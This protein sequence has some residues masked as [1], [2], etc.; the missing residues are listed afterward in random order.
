MSTIPRP[1]RILGL[2]LLVCRSAFAETFDDSIANLAGN[3]A[4]GISKS[5]SKKVSVVDFTDLQ[6]HANELGRFV[7]EELSVALVNAGKGF[8]VMDRANLN[9]LLDEHKLTAQGLVNPENAKKLG[10][11][12]GVDAI[13]IGNVTAFETSVTITAKVI[14]TETTEVIAAAKVSAPKSSEINQLIARSEAMAKSGGQASPDDTNGQAEE[15]DFKAPSSVCTF[16]NI[17]V[18]L[19]SFRASGESGP[20]ALLKIQNRSGTNSVRIGLNHTT[21]G[22]PEVALSDDIG[23]DMALPYNGFRGITLPNH[24]YAPAQNAFQS[25]QMLAAKNE[26]LLFQDIGVLPE[27]GPSQSAMV[28]FKF[29]RPDRGVGDVFRLQAEIV[30]VEVVKGRRVNV[31]LN[32]VALIGIRPK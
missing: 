7:A 4:A 12:S 17:A 16:T 32:N 10:Q 28:E 15:K 1:L 29:G 30:A 19:V 26:S 22:M 13:V 27:I 9:R 11:F 3:V 5:S 14:S 24:V 23:N 20:V 2:I 6:G 31:T 21:S 18:E 8:S 25:L